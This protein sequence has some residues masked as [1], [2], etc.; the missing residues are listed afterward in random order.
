MSRNNT[1]RLKIFKKIKRGEYIITKYSV[2]KSCSFSSEQFLKTFKFLNDITFAKKI[3]PTNCQSFYDAGYD[4]SLINNGEGIIVNWIYGFSQ[5]QNSGIYKIVLTKSLSG[6]CNCIFLKPSIE[7]T[8]KSDVP[9][10][11]DI[12]QGR[13]LN[14][15]E[16]P[17]G[18]LPLESQIYTPLNLTQSF[19]PHL[20]YSVINHNYYKSNIDEIDYNAGYF[21][22]PN[23]DR[24]LYE[25]CSVF[26]IRQDLFGDGVKRNS[27]E[28]YDYSMSGSQLNEIIIKDDGN[29]NLYTQN[30]N[31]GS[32]VSEQNLLVYLGFNEKYKARIEQKADF[33][34]VEDLSLNRNNALV[35]SGA[36]Y[37]NGFLTSG[38]S[39][40]NVGTA[41][42][43]TGVPVFIEHIDK[44]TFTNDDDF[45]VSF[46]MS[47]SLSNQN[48]GSAFGYVFCKQE[49]T[50]QLIKNKVTKNFDF[51]NLKTLSG[52]YPFSIRLINTGSDAG[53]LYLS[54]YG[55]TDEAFITSSAQVTNGYN[56]IICQK[57]GSQFQIF[58]NGVLNSSG[59]S[60]VNGSVYNS[61]D[62]LIGS[63]KRSLTEYYGLLDEVR[64]YNKA[65]S[66]EEIQSLSNTDYYNLE[67]LQTNKIGNIF[68]N[69][70][71]A[72]I[73]TL[74]PSYKNIL[75]GKSGSLV[76]NDEFDN[77][78]GFTGKFKSEKKIFQHEIVIPIRAN[79]FN[80]SSNPTL[81]KNNLANSTEF[82]PFV[83]QSAFNV[84]F[85]TIGLYNRNYELVAVAKLVNPL[86]KYQDKD[87]NVIVRFDVE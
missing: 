11:F 32:F 78:Y 47:A 27:F 38:S 59:S 80:F 44:Y 60:S 62:I 37:G 85:T 81:K 76:Y 64:L 71:T 21:I 34:E 43:C 41:L 28:V 67:A 1:N 56:H 5:N 35:P 23:V 30:I 48:T 3:A 2:Y 16:Y 6:V 65:L 69:S 22:N 55:G 25:S 74:I 75:L 4:C 8:V 12:F 50:T 7:K 79:E 72:I 46:F 26:Q 36:F 77:Y 9:Y 31:T 87:L 66:I 53:K 40:Q 33:S 14:K 39:I 70:G 68:Y 86:P 49:Y 58:V 84:Y 45:A 61:S 57:S 24:N 83:S 29:S 20:I 10:I 52:V 13:Y 73:T 19:D 15:T 63:L 18:K 54:R 17:L 42:N 82:K 51:K